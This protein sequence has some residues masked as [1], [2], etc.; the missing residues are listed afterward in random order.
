VRPRARSGGWAGVGAGFGLAMPAEPEEFEAMRL[1]AV[2]TAPR[3]LVDGRRQ[4]EILDLG[5]AP[6]PGAHDV[7]MVG[8]RAC[9]IRVLAAG[10]VEALE[11]AELREEIEG[12]EECRPADAQSAVPCDRLEIRSGEMAVGLGDQARDSAPWCSEP[13]A[14]QVEGAQD[15]VARDHRQMLAEPG[16]ACRDSVASG[17]RSAFRGPACCDSLASPP[18]PLGRPS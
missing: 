8:G 2:P 13:M 6:A 18:R 15:G 10:Q 11:D 1:D 16:R 3:D 4:A 9:D 7:V 12:P 17:R 5:R 14:G